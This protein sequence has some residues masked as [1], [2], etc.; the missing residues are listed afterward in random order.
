VGLSET[1]FSKDRIEEARMQAISTVISQLQD[2]IQ[3]YRNP[4]YQCPSGESFECGS[5]L[6]GAL[7][8]EMELQG[9]LPVP[10]T[11]F[12]GLSVSELRIKMQRIRSPSWSYGGKSKKNKHPCN[13]GKRVMEIADAVTVLASG[14]E[15]NDFELS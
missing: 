5:I 11:P 9:L 14:P 2:L 13:L 1:D 4:L 10:T 6:Y 12:S 7:T 15:L 8:K 3:E